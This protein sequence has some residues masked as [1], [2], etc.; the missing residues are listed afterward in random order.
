VPNKM[1]WYAHSLP[2]QNPGLAQKPYFP[3]EQN[4]RGFAC[5]KVGARRLKENCF[6]AAREQT[7][8]FYVWQRDLRSLVDCFRLPYSILEDA[9]AVRLRRWKSRVWARFESR[10]ARL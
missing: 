5:P 9:T 3:R 2:A 7:L 1:S 10:R 6:S 4:R 8:F